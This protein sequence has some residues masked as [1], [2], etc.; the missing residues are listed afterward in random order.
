MKLTNTNNTLKVEIFLCFTE[1]SRSKKE[2][3]KK[4]RKNVGKEREGRGVKRRGGSFHGAALGCWGPSSVL[5]FKP[6]QTSKAILSNISIYAD[7][8]VIF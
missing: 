6:T 8:L 2:K 4:V 5:G 7:I 1:N 3:R